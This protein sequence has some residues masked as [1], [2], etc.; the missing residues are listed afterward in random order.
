MMYYPEYFKDLEDILQM[1]L[2]L[3]LKNIEMSHP[4]FRKTVVVQALDQ[5]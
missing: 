4:L 2:G 5:T 3:R 1:C